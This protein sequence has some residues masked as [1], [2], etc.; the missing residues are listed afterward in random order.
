MNELMNTIKSQTCLIENMNNMVKELESMVEGLKHQNQQQAQVIQQHV[1]MDQSCNHQLID[2]EEVIENLG[3]K[4]QYTTEYNINP[5]I[6]A[7]ATTY[8]TPSTQE[9]N[10]YTSRNFVYPENTQGNDLHPTPVHQ[11]GGFEG[12]EEEAG[13]LRESDD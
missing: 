6:E 9:Y 10:D 13:G 12:C 3:E 5:S 1:L 8:A 11:S 4:N 7:I 2:N